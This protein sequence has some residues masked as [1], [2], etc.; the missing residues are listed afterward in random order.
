[1]TNEE[2]IKSL[3]TKEFAKF[4]PCKCCS[5]HGY[6]EELESCFGESCEHFQTEW[7]K[8]ERK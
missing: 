8:A 5:K 2:W 3:P 7:L 1:M 6:D 4:L